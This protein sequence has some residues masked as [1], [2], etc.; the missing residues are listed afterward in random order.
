MALDIDEVKRWDCEQISENDEDDNTF[1]GNQE[2]ITLIWFDKSIDLNSK[3]IQ[4]TKAMLKEINDYTL[5]FT[6]IDACIQYIESIKSETIFLIVSGSDAHNLLSKIHNLRQIDSIFIFCMDKLKYDKTLVEKR[7]YYKIID[8][9]TEQSS[10]IKSIQ[11]TIQ[12]VERQMDIFS[13]YNKNQKSIRD[14]TKESASFIWH[15]LLKEVLQKMPSGDK[16]A[17]QDMIEKCRLYYRG[18]KKELKNIEDF[19]K[20]YSI[21]NAIQWYTKD[22]FLFK[23]INKALRTEDVD[24][25]YTFRFYLIDLC[26][27]LVTN[28]ELVLQ[29][30]ESLKL[31]RGVKY[32]KDE[33]E[34]LKDSNGHLILT[35]GFFSTSHD[36]KVAEIYAGITEMN[37]YGNKNDFESIVF[38]IDY[39]T[40]MHSTTIVA[41]ITCYSQFRDEEEFL[42]DLGTV[43]QI[44]NIS[45][46]Q[47]RKCWIC[48][49]MPSNKGSEIAR[50]YLKFQRNEMNNEKLNTFVLFGNLLY[51]MG[52]YIKCRNYF[53]NL[54]THQSMQDS[55]NITD[56]YTGLGRALIG[57]GQVDLSQKYFQDAY[58]LSLT[59][60]SSPDRRAKI[61]SRIGDTYSFQGKF[62]DALNYYFKG[63][64]LLRKDTENRLLIIYL[65]IKIAEVYYDKGQ[66]DLS[67]A[68]TKKSYKYL[69]NLAPEDHPYMTAYYNNMCMVHYHKG[70]YDLALY[71]QIKAYENRKNIIPADNHMFFSVNINNTGKCYYK[72]YEY[73]QAMKYFQKG[74][75]IARKVLKNDDNYRDMGV[76]INNIGKCYYRQKHYSQALKQYHI[77][78]KLLEKANLKDH[79]DMA[80]TLKNIGEVY[81]DLLNFDLALDYFHQ[82]LFIYKKIFNDLEHRDIAKCLNLIGQVYYYKNTNDDETCLD[83]YNKALEIWQHVLPHNHLDLALCYKNI[84]LFYLNRRFDYIQAEKY[85][86]V[87]YGIYRQVLT[88]DHPHLNEIYDIMQMILKCKQKTILFM[89][90]DTFKLILFLIL[91]TI[92]L[93]I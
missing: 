35:N 44:E 73:D 82:A 87:S 29:C 76:V 12:L 7:D 6:N 30:Y 40:N 48:K 4:L 86:L 26:S 74:L 21:N 57:I 59:I 38:E 84:T 88:A 16:N 24:A 37:P 2:S 69:E 51:D 49:M 91:F 64:K 43:F 67:L 60:E 31:Y 1:H 77:M 90:I 18:N 92:G 33:I 81:L 5:L 13:L 20:N 52:E 72:K 9:F 41:D 71:Y 11:R 62:N 53:Q 93:L 15:Q 75:D 50:E 68:Y 56:I 85:F 3:D 61:L 10:L 42:F 39:N 32:T 14:L 28:H 83:Y 54:L 47:E 63:L 8:I 36:I 19:D 80:Y 17:K 55:S 23:L 78:L 58:D 22:S 89:I 45:Y 46:N 25:L 79:A 27:Q 65:L 70:S 34:N 66:D